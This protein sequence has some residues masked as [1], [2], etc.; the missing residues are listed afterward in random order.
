LLDQFRRASEESGQRLLD[1]FTVHF[2]PQGGEFSDDVSREMQLRRNRSTRT[3]WDPDYFDDSWINSTVQL[4]PLLKYWTS[5]HYSGTKSGITEYNWGA[6]S[7]INGAT[8]QADVL[9]IFGRE[10][11]DLATRW[12]SPPAGSPV[13][14]AFAM[15]RN[16]DGRGSGFGDLSI[17]TDVPQPDDLSAF[18]AVRTSDG[19]LTV[20]IV[21]KVL[22]GTTTANVSLANFAAAT[23]AEAW[24]MTAK[25]RILRLT[26]VPVSGSTLSLDVPA[27]SITLLV[28]A[29]KEE[30]PPR[31]PVERDRIRR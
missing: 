3:L 29:P 17:A 13:H 1:Y 6:E 26:D 27:Q 4:I 18:A 31:P 12:A 30:Q 8:A 10:G 2:Y 7:H 20:M 21:N 25:N 11:L 15:Y 16:Y 23:K 22:D 19:K 9:G 28:I 5:S 14:T 24:Q